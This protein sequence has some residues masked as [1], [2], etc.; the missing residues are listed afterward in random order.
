MKKFL[1]IILLFFMFIPILVNAEV[2]DICNEK[3][4]SEYYMSNLKIGQELGTGD[5]IYRFTPSDQIIDDE[6]TIGNKYG[7]ETVYSIHS[8]FYDSESDS[9]IYD[10]VDA[11]CFVIIVGIRHMSY[12]FSYPDNIEYNKNKYWKLE[13]VKI[14]ALGEG[15]GFYFKSYK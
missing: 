8:N 4:V 6:D 12:N 5:I 14:E 13:D 10:Y 9:V 1:F 11:Y 15:L 2:C 7:V 3:N